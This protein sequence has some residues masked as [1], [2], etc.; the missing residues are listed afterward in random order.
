M[1][2]GIRW[3]FQVTVT[4]V[5]DEARAEA[6]ELHLGHVMEEFARLDACNE[7][8][9]DPTIGAD[10][11]TGQVDVQLE[12]EAVSPSSAV[13]SALAL[14]RTAV[15]AAGGFTGSW[16]ANLHEREGAVEYGLL[17]VEAEP[18]PL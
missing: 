6:L 1:W 8:M 11:S 10:V 17:E 16:D 3:R 7:D 12:I 9:S 18:V 13:D 5:G 2:Y 4:G 14:L 15:H